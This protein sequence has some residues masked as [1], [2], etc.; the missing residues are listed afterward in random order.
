MST[1][2]NNGSNK[3]QILQSKIA[4][5][6][7]VIRWMAVFWLA[8]MLIR[9]CQPLFYLPHF[10]EQINTAHNLPAG[11][12]TGQ[13]A[14]YNRLV[15]IFLW[16]CTATIGLATW[17]LMSS[18][19]RGEIFSESAALKLMRL[20]QAALF[21]ILVSVVSRPL[22]FYVLSPTI[23]ASM[24]WETFFSPQD[25]LYVLIS[26]FILS[27]ARIFRVAAEI[28]AENKQFI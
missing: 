15:A 26:A 7:H 14:I 17:S 8:W 23:L 21:A 4:W 22:S 20:G 9:L 25:L 1:T 13:G 19:L 5:I 18:Y 10:V 11:T 24:N 2:P 16:A 6:C 27:L 12:V 28:N 3:M